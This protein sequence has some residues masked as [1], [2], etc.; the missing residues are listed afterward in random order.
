MT[1]DDSLICVVVEVTVEGCD[2][3]NCFYLSALPTLRSMNL[4]TETSDTRRVISLPAR[5]SGTDSR[6]SSGA[7]AV[8]SWYAGCNRVFFRE[9]G[10]GRDVK[11]STQALPCASRAL[12]WVRGG[13][14][15]RL[16]EDGVGF[17]ETRSTSA[18]AEPVSCC[19]IHASNGQHL[20]QNPLPLAFCW[21]PLEYGTDG[22]ALW[23][24]A[25]QRGGWA[26]RGD[27]K[28]LDRWLLVPG[29]RVRWSQAVTCVSLDRW[30]R[31]LRWIV[32]GMPWSV[33]HWGAEGE[34]SPCTNSFLDQAWD[35]PGF[36]LL[37]R[38][39]KVARNKINII[40]GLWF[41]CA[42]IMSEL[43]KNIPGYSQGIQ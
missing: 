23:C 22:A 26:G 18:R 11:G 24:P 33:A 27:S 41:S 36:Q 6:T 42:C 40:S 15:R 34:S 31:F 3:C 7:V 13:V 10:V 32:Q 21:A 28:K 17:G 16:L 5:V 12:L 39:Q 9:Q 4:R 43:A 20:H 38:G 37:R 1:K 29:S 25:W 30:L 19:W 2:Y 14:Q 8:G 35:P